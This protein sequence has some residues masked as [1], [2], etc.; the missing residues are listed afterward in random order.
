M[1]SQSPDLELANVLQIHLLEL[2]KYVPPSD[3]GNV[4]NPNEKWAFFFQQAVN[5]TARE[6]IDRL[7]EDAFAEAAGVLEMIA[8][9]PRDRELYEARLK[10]QRDEQSRLDAARDQSRAEGVE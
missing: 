4:T 7:G 10:L 5:M 6:L 8:K 9:S 2:P 3:N 1:R